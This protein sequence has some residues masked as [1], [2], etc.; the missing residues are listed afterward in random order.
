MN[1][2]T[3]KIMSRLKDNILCDYYEDVGSNVP[4]ERGLS[5]DIT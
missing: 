5:L 4:I 2:A 1:Q 3:F